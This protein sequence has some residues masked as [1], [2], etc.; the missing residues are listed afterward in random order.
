MFTLIDLPYSSLAPVISDKTLSFHHGKHLQTY[1]DNL[2]K[3]VAGTDLEGKSLEEIVI[4]SAAEGAV[5]KSPAIF[6]NAGQILNHHLYFTQFCP[7]HS[8]ATPCHSE[9]S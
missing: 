1:V 5:E 9:S 4:S 8:E 6:N 3:L 2:N 7:R